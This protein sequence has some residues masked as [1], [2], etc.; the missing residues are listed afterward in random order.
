MTGGTVTTY[1]PKHILAAALAAIAVFTCT[2]RMA[3]GEAP[4][5]GTVT[6]IAGGF[7]W[8]EGPA[9][10]P[11]GTIYFTDNR[12]NLLWRIGPDGV[13]SVAMNPAHRLNGMFALPDG[14]ILGCAGDPKALVKYDPSSGTFTTL[15]D[16]QDGEPFNAPNDCWADSRGG[17]YF[18]DPYWGREPGRSRV[19]YLPPG[20]TEPVTVNDSMTRP[21]GV[22]GSPD[23]TVLYVTDWD[24]KRTFAF[25]IGPDG[26][27]A[28]KREFAPVGDDGMTV[29]EHG[30]VYLTGAVL[31]V[32]SPEGMLLGIIE[33]LETPANCI[34]CGTGRTTL[35]ITARTSVYT[36]PMS[37]R[38]HR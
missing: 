33:T 25:D 22:I 5:A 19:R 8:A 36:V 21:N 26:M 10:I 6:K 20:A 12:E 32:Y 17:V 31:S 23:G 27:L 1:R 2:G 9:E 7:T 38:G 30:N 24:D 34:F 4:V 18:T 14:T 11:G 3:A 37:V 35:L 16:S 29:D 15:C 13:A 28:N